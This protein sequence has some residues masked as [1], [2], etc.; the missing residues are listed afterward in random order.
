[1]LPVEGVLKEFD[2][3]VSN[4]VLRGKAYDNKIVVSSRLRCEG[5]VDCTLGPCEEV[6]RIEGG[7]F[8]REGESQTER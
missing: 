2:N 6:T 1:M 8:N 3:I 7:L 4:G 5:S